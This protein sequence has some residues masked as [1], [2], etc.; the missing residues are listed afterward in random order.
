MNTDLKKKLRATQKSIK[1]TG[2]RVSAKL[3]TAAAVSTMI[4]YKFEKRRNMENGD[5]GIELSSLLLRITVTPK[6]EDSVS[7]K[8][9]LS[10]G[11]RPMKEVREDLK[12]IESLGKKKPVVEPPV[13]ISEEDAE[14][15]KKAEKKLHKLERK[16]IKKR[17]KAIRK[18]QKEA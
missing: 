15:L 14:K 1:K 16:I 18:A 3:F 4:P 9:L 17:M 10:V 7:G 8:T 2:R 13:E 12:K 6:C 5:D 11:L